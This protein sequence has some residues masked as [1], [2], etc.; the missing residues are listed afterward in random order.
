MASSTLKHSVRLNADESLGDHQRRAAR[1]AD[2]QGEGGNLQR[3]RT[4][5][6]SS[7]SLGSSWSKNANVREFQAYLDDREDLLPKLANIEGLQRGAL[8]VV[9]Q[10]LPGSLR[11]DPREMPR[12]REEK[13]R[14]RRRGVEAAHPVG[15]RS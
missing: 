4:S 12:C 3:F 14:D 6:R 13:E 1:A 10:G 11:G 2:H 7:L 8:E 15:S 9:S 5:G